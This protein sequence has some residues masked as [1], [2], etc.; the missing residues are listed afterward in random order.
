ML[1]T[2]VDPRAALRTWVT[3]KAEGLEASEALDNV[4]LFEQRLLTSLHLP[5]LILLIE[6]LRSE[7]IDVTALASGDFAT[8]DAIV[9]RFFAQ[10]SDR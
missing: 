9:D 5:E 6:R 4:P 3:S 8:I 10:V 2:D 7:A 1:P